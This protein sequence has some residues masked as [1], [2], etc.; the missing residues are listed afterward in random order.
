MAQGQVHPDSDVTVLS[1]P[2]EVPSLVGGRFQREV[3]DT[4]VFPAVLPPLRNR[5]GLN[6]LA[7]SLAA[8]AQGRKLR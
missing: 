2:R 5:L 4:A 6:Q 7:N 1:V 3:L 8:L